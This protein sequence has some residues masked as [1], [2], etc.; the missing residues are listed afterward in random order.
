MPK[1]TIALVEGYCIFGGWM[2]AAAMDVLFAHE[3]A[4]FLPGQT[5]YF[6]VP[7]DLGAKRAK[8]ILFEHRF[9][10]AQECFDNGF[11]NRVF[12][13]ENLERET[14]AYAG[15]VAENYLANPMGVETT[16]RTINHMLDAQGFT[17]EIGAS[18]DSFAAM[19]GLAPIKHPASADGGYARTGIAKKNFEASRRY[20]Q[21]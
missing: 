6:S 7:W 14:L 1:P 5:Q 2:I 20:V 9:M 13:T 16:K 11:V 15:R 3:D 12:D 10:S 18:F 8:E 17:A 19:I 21:E 4:R